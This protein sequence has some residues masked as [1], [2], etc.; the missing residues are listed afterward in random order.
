M[1]QY[2]ASAMIQISQE[3]GG[4]TN[5]FSRETIHDRLKK[6]ALIYTLDSHAFFPRKKF[7]HAH[8]FP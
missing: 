2:D 5:A 1:S 4:V 6:R 7:S 8:F 3:T